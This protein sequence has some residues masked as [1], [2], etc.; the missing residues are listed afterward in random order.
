MDNYGE[1]IPKGGGDPIP[2]FAER[3]S[4]G[5]RENCE[6]VLRFSNVSAHHCLL[7]VDEGYWFVKDLN[8]RNGV[9]VNGI[10]LIAEM[11]KRLDP[12][13]TLSV[14]KH[15]YIIRYEPVELGALGAPPA[16]DAPSAFMNVSLLKRAGMERRKDQQDGPESSKKSRR[17]NPNDNSAGR[18]R[19]PS[20]DDDD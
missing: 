9:K 13:D 14:A 16:D 5:R 2:L 10:P 20:A 1:L 7:T 15:H 11:R 4:V 8:S 6:I 19:P 12:G 3:L 17:Y 18:L